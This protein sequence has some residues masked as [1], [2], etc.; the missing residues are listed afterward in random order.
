[1]TSLGFFNGIQNCFYVVSLTIN[2]IIAQYYKKKPSGSKT[3]LDHV[4]MDCCQIHGCFLTSWTTLFNIGYFFE[5]LDLKVAETIFFIGKLFL[6][7]LLAVVQAKVVINALLVY[8]IEIIDETFLTITRIAWIAYLG[9][10]CLLDFTASEPTSSYGLEYLS[11]TTDKSLV[12]PATG[13]RIGS[14]VLL[15]SLILFQYFK[16]VEQKEKKEALKVGIGI[17][18]L[19]FFM[20]LY[21]KSYGTDEEEDDHA[22]LA[23]GMWI[24]TELQ[25]LDVHKKH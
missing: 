15:I 23:V 21:F 8:D 13:F 19:A 10:M 17:T 11:G 4:V 2:R 18:I 22:E 20:V 5:L 25:A 7:S 6:E 14:L 3:I 16:P 9:L 12:L 1:M 24:L